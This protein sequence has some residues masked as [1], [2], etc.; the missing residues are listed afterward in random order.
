[1]ATIIHELLVSLKILFIN[2]CRR[3]GQDIDLTFVELCKTRLNLKK[4]DPKNRIF[5][6]ENVAP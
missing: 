4:K 3:F 5:V 1:M 6:S 2:P